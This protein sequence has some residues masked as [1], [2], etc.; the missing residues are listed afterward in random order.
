MNLLLAFAVA[1]SITMALIP[2]LYRFAGRMHVLDQPQP[3]K[4][5]TRP[6]PRIG[7]IA[8]AAGVFVPL[9][10]WLRNEALLDAYLVG[11]LLLVVMGVWD[12]RRDLTPR[13]K[14]AAQIAAALCVVVWGGIQ[15]HSVTL[16]DRVELPG[17]VSLP[18]TVLFIVGITN[19][20]NLS[21]GLDGLAG[22]TTLLGSCGIALLAYSAGAG[23]VATLAVILAGSLLGFL[24]YNTYPARVFM[25]DGGSQFLG[26]TMAVLALLLTQSDDGPISA[27]LPLL[28]LG[29][30]I[31]DTLAVMAQRLH[32][33]RSPFAPDKNHVH[34]KLLALG[35]D[36]H[37]AVAAIYGVQALLF[38]AAWF[39]RYE[40]DVAIL[41][42]FVA[43]AVAALVALFAAE[44]GGWR[45]RGEL[46]AAASDSVSPL[47]RRMTWLRQQDHLP[48][49]LRLV[50]GTTAAIYAIWTV[51]T[52]ATVPGDVGT[53]A[54]AVLCIGLLGLWLSRRFDVGA[55]IGQAAAYVTVMI[56][57]YLPVRHPGAGM[58]SSAV[59][60][61]VFA[62][63]AACI[64]LT[65]RLDTTR[66]FRLTPLDLI[67]IFAAL[68]LPNLP[69]SLAQG[70]SLGVAAL[71][72]VVLFYT[73]E[74]H[75]GHS[76]ATRRVVH[77]LT[78]ALLAAIAWR[79]L[80]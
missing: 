8:M 1:M 31:V 43:F 77:A 25:G 18:L 30:P 67:V 12:D 80:L 9:L 65:F 13:A 28:L 75:V 14:F 49:W 3:R 68:A 27:A 57:V 78:A 4:V 50:T 22:G 47:A 41:T 5:H 32:E 56:V 37:E 17:F 48:A 58:P 59:T 10:V 23:F 66:R 54:L 55:W 70:R 21:D 51:A 26:F 29:L 42:A 35:F 24:R 39:L 34:H 45:W 71:S 20:I 64:A 63:L 72:L 36:H 15:I 61:A 73:V 76:I 38:V 69:G 2:L 46:P 62:L 16:T 60:L 44:R 19:A 11:A 79:G 6:I 40:S 53:L 7:G 33:G 52:A 74:M